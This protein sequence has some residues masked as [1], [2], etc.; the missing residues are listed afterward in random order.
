MYD[1][2]TLCCPLQVRA[3]LAERRQA[4]AGRRAV[5][6]DVLSILQAVVECYVSQ[7]DAVSA[8]LVLDGA[9]R[10]LQVGGGMHGGQLHRAGRGQ[11][12]VA[13]SVIVRSWP[14]VFGRCSL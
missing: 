12:A 3:L 9:M 13:Y 10:D 8:A 1:A 11:R 6:G 2:G 4:L 7:G 14:R 5:L